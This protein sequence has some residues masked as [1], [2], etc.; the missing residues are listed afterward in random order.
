[1]SGWKS[2]GGKAL[3]VGTLLAITQAL[4][5][6]A[7]AGKFDGVTLRIGTWGG[8]WKA[9]M[10]ERIVPR[11]EAEGGK[12]EFVTGS[13]QANF[14]KVVAA[15]GQAPFD[16]MEIL[17]AQVSDILE[18]GFLQKLNLE[19]IPNK[20]HMDAYQY[21]E[22]MIGSWHTQEVICYNK[23]KFAEL[24]IPAPTTYKDLVRPELEGRI[25]FPDINS[26]GGLANLG[27]LAYATGGDENN[28]KPALE[29]LK[30]MKILKFWSQGGELVQQYQSGDVYASV[31]N[32]GWCLRA[33][34]AGVNVTSVHPF[35]K[36]GMVGVAKEGWL[37]IMS[38]STNVEAAHW[39][40]N[41][42]LDEEFQLLFAKKSG[43]T[44][45]NRNAIA[46]MGEDPVIAEMLVLDPVKI[47][48]QQR[49]DYSKFQ[50]SD[51]TDEW[52]RMVAQ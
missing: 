2:T 26:G 10:E 15:R 12:I 6:P 24:G 36:E 16:I 22:N 21:N 50:I 39:F 32:A 31:S 28:I 30:A 38:N 11:F 41:E 44:P 34:N 14:A 45:I 48:K 29:M 25:S 7:L 5:G 37:G 47:Q 43:I 52:N 9:N 27:S 19:L 33:K 1:M 8:S 4:A 23:D 46:R 18:A 35:I 13:P 40:L 17:D 49:T 20:Q 42:Y 51:W 3:I